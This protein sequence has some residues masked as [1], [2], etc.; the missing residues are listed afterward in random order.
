M[1]YFE[2]SSSGSSFY[3][4]TRLA[5][6]ANLFVV[7]NSTFAAIDFHKEINQLI[8]SHFFARV[9][10]FFEL[11][12]VKL[13]RDYSWYWQLF[14]QLSI[15]FLSFFQALVQIVFLFFLKI[16]PKKFISKLKFSVLDMLQYW[17]KWLIGFIQN[18]FYSLLN[19]RT[20]WFRIKIISN[21]LEISSQ[22][23]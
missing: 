6:R 2:R 11:A 18:C 22:V 3:S 16:F 17:E 21:F 7:N 12:E 1:L 4:F 20:T 10:K 5:F 13:L 9:K 8:H 15:K 19:L 23:V 14:L